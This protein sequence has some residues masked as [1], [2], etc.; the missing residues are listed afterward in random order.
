[1]ECK[2]KKCYIHGD[3]KVRGARAVATVVSD[4]GKNSVVVERDI[5]KYIS[6]YERYARRKSKIAAHNPECI[7]AKVG[8]V[9][10]VGECRRISKTKSWTVVKIIKKSEKAGKIKRKT[11]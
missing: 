4:K 3:V 2:D 10:E 5:V 6:K 9:V 1:M 11:R 7:G 8:D